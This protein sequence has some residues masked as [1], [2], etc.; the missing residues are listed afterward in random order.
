M[1]SFK[2]EY[3]VNVDELY[4]DLE[5]LIE[6]GEVKRLEKDLG[7]LDEA[8]VF[9]QTDDYNGF[10]YSDRG[11]LHNLDDG[12]FESHPVYEVLKSYYG[13]GVDDAI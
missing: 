11:T 8:H 7:N 4:E 1:S 9:F 12:D 5:D 13:N 2:S 6:D 10:L 3:R